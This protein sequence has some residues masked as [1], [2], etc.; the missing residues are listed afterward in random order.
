MDPVYTWYWN[1]YWVIWLQVYSTK[2]K[3]IPGGLGCIWNR[4]FF[5]VN[6]N[7]SR[8]LPDTDVTGKHIIH[9]E[10]GGCFGDPMT[11]WEKMKH[12]DGVQENNEG[13]LPV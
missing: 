9:A 4:T 11:H 10:Q 3:S 2:Y 7:V 13:V 1:A 6:A 5:R 12:L 8:C